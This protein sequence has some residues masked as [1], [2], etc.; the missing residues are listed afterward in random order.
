M[1]PVCP[2]GPR[3]RVITQCSG[4][5]SGG[6][7]AT[8]DRAGR[9]LRAVDFS[10]R[11]GCSLVLGCAP[12]SELLTLDQAFGIR[13]PASTAPTPRARRVA[14]GLGEIGRIRGAL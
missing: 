10:I 1:R 5:V 3:R 12:R 9:T 14:I 6:P 7:D 8:S 13:S 11:R 4:F 2:K